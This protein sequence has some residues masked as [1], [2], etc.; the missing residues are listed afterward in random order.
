MTAK[1]LVEVVDLSLSYRRED[2]WRPALHNVSFEIAAGEA[3]GLVGES[4]CGKSTLA[5][6]LLGFRAANARID[7]GRVVFQGRDVARL[8]RIELDRL[9]GDRM[10]LVPQNPTTALSPGMRVGRQIVEVLEILG[11]ACGAWSSC[12]S[13]SDCRRPSGWPPAIRTSYRAD[14]SSAW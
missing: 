10:A 6:Q 3:F 4:G 9:R 7:G 12:F 5:Y 13:S 11:A 1:P 8:P 2:G 14:S